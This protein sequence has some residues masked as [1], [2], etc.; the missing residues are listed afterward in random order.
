[1]TASQNELTGGFTVSITYSAFIGRRWVG[2]CGGWGDLHVFILVILNFHVALVCLFY[3]AAW[4]QFL[5]H[6]VKNILKC[7]IIR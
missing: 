5:D 7:H 3:W 4:S 2:G 1:M 6:G